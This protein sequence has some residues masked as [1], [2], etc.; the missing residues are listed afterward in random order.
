MIACVSVAALLASGMMPLGCSNQQKG[1]AGKA[2]SVSLPEDPASL[3]R[4]GR[5]SE[6]FNEANRL[7]KSASGA[8]RERL[9]LIAGLA[10]QAQNRNTEAQYWLRP[11]T[12]S[13]DA[14]ISGRALAGVGLIDQEEDRHQAAITELKAAGS[15]LSGEESAKASFYLGESYSAIG[16]R[17]EAM[18]AYRAA[19]N[20]TTDPRLRRLANDR[21]S[22]DSYTVQLGAYRDPGKARSVASAAAGRARSLGLPPPKV[23]PRSLPDG[24]FV[25]L[26]QIGSYKSLKQAQADRARFGGES[27][28]ARASSR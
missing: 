2:S 13:A 3:Y 7:V 23:V 21:L 11:L 24:R 14:D 6:A 18:D 26:V 10:A 19:A 25:N 4:A 22:L 28:V 12:S 27:V 5:F 15:K 1:S 9:G 8:E 16:S 17:L 20:S